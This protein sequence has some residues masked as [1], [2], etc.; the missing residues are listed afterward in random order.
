VEWLSFSLLFLAAGVIGLL[1]AGRNGAPAQALLAGV[2]PRFRPA[3]A[4]CSWALE[5]MS[6]VRS[7]LQELGQPG[8]V[9]EGQCPQKRDVPA[10]QPMWGQDKLWASTGGRLPW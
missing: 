9:N 8:A 5:E 10:K 3:S 2:L 1:S 7:I 6:W 4:F